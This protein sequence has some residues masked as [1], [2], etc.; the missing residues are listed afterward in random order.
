MEI[1]ARPP[2]HPGHKRVRM[3]DQQSSS[4]SDT[5]SDVSD[6][7]D[8]SHDSD[9][10]TR[11]VVTKTSKTTRVITV[12]GGEPL[13][14]TT[15]RSTSSSSTVNVGSMSGGMKP[16]AAA[17]AAL[18]SSTQ[19]IQFNSGESQSGSVVVTTT[20]T[21]SHSGGDNA[22]VVGAA[23]QSELERKVS[24][25]EKMLAT[26]QEAARKYRS[27]A[28]DLSGR[29]QGVAELEAQLNK[30]KEEQ[31]NKMARFRSATMRHIEG[32][33]TQA[34]DFESQRQQ[35]D[36]EKTDLA[37]QREQLKLL[38]SQIRQRAG[39]LRQTQAEKDTQIKDLQ[40]KIKALEGSPQ[41]IP[42]S[43]MQK[44]LLKFKEEMDDLKQLASAKDKRITELEMQLNN[45]QPVVKTDLSGLKKVK[46]EV[47]NLRREMEIKEDEVQN[48][49]RKNTMLELQ[50]KSAE[51][52][53]SNDAPARSEIMV[54]REQ[55][56]AVQQQSEAR[57][58]WK[59]SAN[60]PPPQ[61]RLSPNYAARYHSFNLN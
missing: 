31:A 7:S 11:N 21:V 19:P 27:Q 48:L 53:A 13:T 5:S 6:V 47:S 23:S 28:Q 37:N 32:L 35:L 1:A 38:Q 9:D 10:D 34:V 39:S 15:N 40:E 42:D 55:L 60:K 26:S 59:V 45:Q 25:L 2:T 18:S 43:K 29:L 54:L 3:A 52:R 4:H 50:M 57:P 61:T 14:T 41:A 12:G 17:L 20:K 51:Q 8:L 56:H 22:V 46:D 30:E 16:T 58:N 44:M 24:N 33:R 49:M 36:D